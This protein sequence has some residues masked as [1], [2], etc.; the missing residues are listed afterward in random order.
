MTQKRMFLVIIFFLVGST[1]CGS[2]GGLQET[3]SPDASRC[4]SPRFAVHFSKGEFV[5]RRPLLQLTAVNHSG[6]IVVYDAHKLEVFDRGLH[7]NAGQIPVALGVVALAISNL[8][9]IAW[10][11]SDPEKSNAALEVHVFR[12]GHESHGT[13]F[14]RQAWKVPQTWPEL[15][16]A[17]E[18]LYISEQGGKLT[19]V[20]IGK[21]GYEGAMVEVPP[22]ETSD[23]TAALPR[24]GIIQYRWR[25]HKPTRF[26]IDDTIKSSTT[27]FANLFALR[28]GRG[29]DLR[30]DWPV[31]EWQETDRGI[32][33][34]GSRLSSTGFGPWVHLL[35]KSDGQEV[36]R[37]IPMDANC[38]VTG[39]DLFDQSSK[40]AVLL[41]GGLIQVLDAANLGIIDQI[42]LPTS[43]EYGA[44]D[45]VVAL[46][47]RRFV[48]R[49]GSGL[50][51]V[52][53]LR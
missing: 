34:L 28:E 24:G 4:A 52:D 7:Q 15:Y 36:A 47:T 5:W 21:S 48:V 43:V 2:A 20:R 17:G 39:M 33:F 50:A 25:T 29:V 37:L 46:S 19:E 40:V 13:P 38:W 26:G 14:P 1:V 6:M 44:A 12:D 27:F 31:R 45:D 53:T 8:G 51:V 35:R 18:R 11:E 10:L 32:I 16:F 42:L 41:K 9:T 49:T 23:L 30:A 22:T 3:H